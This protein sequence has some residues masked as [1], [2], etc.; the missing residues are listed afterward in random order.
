[1]PLS[2]ADEVIPPGPSG[3]A[4][5]HGTDE[6]MP[7]AESAMPFG[8]EEAMPPTEPHGSGEAM[9]RTAQGT[10]P[11][12]FSLE[13]QEE[14]NRLYTQIAHERLETEELRRQVATM[15]RE[16]ARMEK[17]QAHMDS[18]MTHR[19]IPPP[20]PSTPEQLARTDPPPSAL[21][22]SGLHPLRQLPQ[23]TSPTQ[24]PRVLTPPRHVSPSN[25]TPLEG[26]SSPRLETTACKAGARDADA[27]RDLGGI[28]TR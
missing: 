5:P 8:M 25:A 21:P 18:I 13:T 15:A 17:L 27:T 14:I 9:P 19:A 16:N 4:V 10:S 2:P 20:G 3:V 28:H 12:D 26:F 24:P 22:V 6:A 7:Q 11:Q 23:G 1:M